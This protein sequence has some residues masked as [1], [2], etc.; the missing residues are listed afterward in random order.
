MN[1]FRVLVGL[2]I[3]LC[4]WQSICE[5]LGATEGLTVDCKVTCG[6]VVFLFFGVARFACIGEIV[7]LRFS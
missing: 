2:V 6:N 5:N 7:P 4:V 3:D 1:L